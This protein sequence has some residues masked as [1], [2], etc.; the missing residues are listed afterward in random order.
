MLKS[1][2]LRGAR[3]RLTAVANSDLGV[4]E[5]WWSDAGFLRL[6]DAGPAYPRSR[7]RLAKRVEEG[8]KGQS[9]FL[10]G[11][12]T[13]SDDLLIGLLELDGVTWSNGTTFF[14]VAIGD[15]ANR[16]QGYGREAT[17]LGLDF[18]FQ[19]LNLH[20]VCLTVFEYNS[21]AIALYE[22][23]GFTHEGSFREHLHRDGKR[24]DMLLYGMLRHEWRAT[25]QGGP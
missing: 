16:R 19:E 6:Y 15:E 10:F 3:L 25:N 2:L 20:R 11:I 4:I 22:R 17:S 7:A 24:H 23:M 12:R 14:S 5:N 1:N 18:A 13:L 21:A 8:Q 9:N